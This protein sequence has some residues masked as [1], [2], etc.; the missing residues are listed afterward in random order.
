MHLRVT[1]CAIEERRGFQRGFVGFLVEGQVARFRAGAE[2]FDEAFARFGGGLVGPPT[3]A[4]P[5]GET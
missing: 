1:R 2:Q 3:P 5:P 4:E